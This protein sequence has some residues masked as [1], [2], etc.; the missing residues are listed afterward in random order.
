MADDAPGEGTTGVSDGAGTSDGDRA[1]DPGDLA[2]EWPAQ[3]ADT[4]VRVVDSVR[5]KT[6]EPAQTAARGIVYGLVAA[7]LAIVAVVLVVVGAFRALA[8]YLPG[9]VWAA[10]AIVGVIF[11]L[12]GAALWF[13][14]RP[15]SEPSTDD[16]TASD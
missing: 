11:S 10:H 13:Q 14:R 12:A 9:D 15:P 2:A 3:A 1:V 7:F 6:T 16:A 5:E 4:V 8:N